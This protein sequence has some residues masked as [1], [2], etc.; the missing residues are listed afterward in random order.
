MKAMSFCLCL[1][2]LVVDSNQYRNYTPPLW[3]K[4][5]TITQHKWWVFPSELLCFCVWHNYEKWWHFH[6]TPTMRL[7]LVYFR[8]FPEILQF[9]RSLKS[10]ISLSLTSSSSTTFNIF[11]L[12]IPSLTFTTTIR[13]N[14]ETMWMDFVGCCVCTVHI[15]LAAS[16]TIYNILETL[17]TLDGQTV[18]IWCEY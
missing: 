6:H 15:E 9:S 5:T 7:A 10:F 3:T 13:L 17:R 16:K 12:R 11:T 8:R 4:T 2:L 14:D 18:S 1:W